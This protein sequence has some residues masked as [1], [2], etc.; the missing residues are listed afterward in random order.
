[1]EKVWALGAPRLKRVK[2]WVLFN[3]IFLDFFFIW[4]K[5][6]LEALE[7]PRPLDPIEAQEDSMGARKAQEPRVSEETIEK[8]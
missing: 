5:A 7:A 2:S 3:S 4:K 8:Q 1:M 6:W